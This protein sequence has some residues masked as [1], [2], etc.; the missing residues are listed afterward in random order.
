MVHK[1]TLKT[2]FSFL[3]LCLFAVSFGFGQSIFDNPIN[4]N[5]IDAEINNP[6]TNGQNVVPNITVS[7]IGKGAGVSG[8]ATGTNDRYNLRGW[9]TLGL[10]P[11]DYFEFT[12]TPNA[13]YE[14]D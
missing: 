12:I 4:E 2:L 13:G 9:S 6:Y 11:T 14:I 5:A 1:T 8:I 7:G 3:I 10:D